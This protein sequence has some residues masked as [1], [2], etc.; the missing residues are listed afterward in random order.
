METDDLEELTRMI[1]ETGFRLN[2]Y[3]RDVIMGSCSLVGR[4]RGSL[5][6]LGRQG[7]R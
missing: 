5:M 6:L 4:S 3:G 7:N 1:R 2:S